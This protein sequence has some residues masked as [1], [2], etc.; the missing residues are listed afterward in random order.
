MRKLLDKL[1]KANYANNLIFVVLAITFFLLTLSNI[2][3]LSILII[4][5]IYIFKKKRS[6]LKLIIILITIILIIYLLYRYDDNYRSTIIEGKIIDCTYTDTYNKYIIRT[7]IHK[8]LLYD[9][10]NANLK[11]GMIVN[12]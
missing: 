8:V 1:Q 3:Y 7:G 6:L 11:V 4:Y 9:Y 5:S 2:S 12:I 10:D